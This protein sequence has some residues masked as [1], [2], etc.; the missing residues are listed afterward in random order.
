M[1]TLRI[2]HKISN[3]AEWKKAFDSDPINRKKS[4]VKRYRIYRPGDDEK[5]VI[6]DLEF[7]QPEQAQKT[8]ISLHKMFGKIEGSLVFGARTKILNLVETTE[9]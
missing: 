5:F 4:G 6:I 7:D 2:E 3:Y 8:Q 1:T 9:L